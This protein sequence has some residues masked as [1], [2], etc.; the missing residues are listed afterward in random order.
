M[1]GADLVNHT[2]SF[3]DEGGVVS[4][5]QTVRLLDYLHAVTDLQN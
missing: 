5:L 3:D 4:V 2:A 1:Q